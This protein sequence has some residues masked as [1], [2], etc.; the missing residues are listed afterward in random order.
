VQVGNPF[1]EKLLLEA[2]LEALETGAVVGMQDLGA[3]GLTSSTVEAASRGG[4]GVTVD[5]AKVSRRESGM[6]PYEVMLSESQ[7]RMLVVVERGR[8]DEV[9]AIFDRWE[10]HSDVIGA[11]TADGLVR[12]TDGDTIVAEV[13]ARYFTDECPTYYREG[14]EAP[15]I[16]ALRAFDPA[17][18]PDLMEDSRLKIEDQE[19]AAVQPA[20]DAPKSSIFNLESGIYTLLLDAG[21]E[22]PLHAL[23]V[24]VV[25][26]EHPVEEPLGARR[27]LAPVVALHPLDVHHLAGAG[28]LEAPLGAL[29]GLHLGH[30]VLLLQT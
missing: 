11:V 18:L 15:E 25:E 2:C 14:H 26:H 27:L 21:R 7:E 10:L 19:S 28:D 16:A 6:T 5:V 9:R 30:R 23:A 29:V 20:V 22:E 13:P 1:L 24:G 4:V 8:E 3:A 12:V 17:V